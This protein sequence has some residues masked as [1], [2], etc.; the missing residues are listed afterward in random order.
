MSQTTYSPAY[1]ILPCDDRGRTGLEALDISRRAIA[2]RLAATLCFSL[3][4]SS[5][6][7]ASSSSNCRTWSSREVCDS[8]SCAALCLSRNSCVSCRSTDIGGRRLRKVSGDGGSSRSADNEPFL[9]G[10]GAI[11]EQ[12]RGCGAFI[13]R[14]LISFVSFLL[15]R[16]EGL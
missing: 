14:N 13:V 7:S 15:M 3:A 4:T 6:A 12:C 16:A 1:P 9:V 8:L 5:A 2:V 11:R 10:V